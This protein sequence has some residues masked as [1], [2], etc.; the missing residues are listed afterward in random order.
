M[1]GNTVMRRLRKLALAVLAC[2]VFAV[3]APMYFAERARDDT[4]AG[5][6][7]LASPRDLHV[8]TVPVRLSSAPDLMLNRAVIYDY[9]LM[10]P[11]GATSQVLL[12]GPV[13]TLNAAGLRASGATDPDPTAAAEPLPH[14]IQQ[15][16]ALGFDLIAIRRG[17][18]HITMLDG[19]V[20]TLTDIQA[21][22]KKTRRGQIASLGSFTM[23]GQRLA[24]DATFGQPDKKQPQRWPLQVSFRGNL[25]QGTFEGQADLSEDVQLAGKTEL[26]IPS[27]RRIGRWFGL[28]L[29]V[30]E[31]FNAATIKGDL[32]WARRSLAF[33]K[34]HIV[35][36]G[37]EGNGGVVL[38][39]AGER[40]RLEAT[41]D[42]AGLNL[43]PY[44]DAMRT[45]LFG[46]ELPVTWGAAFDASLPMIRYLDADMRISANRVTLKD[47]AFGQGGATIT[48][49]SGKLHADIAELEVPGGGTL[50]AQVTAIMTEAAPRYAVRAKAENLEMGP[51]SASFLGSPALTGRAGLTFD[52][53][54]TGYS[55][56]ELAR[57]LS[58]KA[59][60]SMPEGG[61]VALDLRAVRQAAKAGHRG[62][63]GLAKSHT[64][65]ERLE[66]RSLI[67]DG[68]AFAEDIQARAGTL[69]LA[70]A[71]RFGLV[72]GNMDARLLLKSDAPPDGSQKPADSANVANEAVTLR[73]PWPDPLLRSE[74]PEPVRPMP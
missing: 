71:G 19:S 18:L 39:L 33:E 10:A 54:S 67:I 62:W 70:L 74:E 13:L 34:A 15:I 28:P 30:T 26:A 49:Q 22:V 64:N 23:R 57:R 21:E 24:F 41:L 17:T 61:R 6:A 31:G 47:Y 11:P 8:I 37:N 3:L 29:Y 58:G 46:F 14:I 43:T 5:S 36:D 68:V 16:S 9:D 38:N 52:L 60:L 63:V 51:A 2:L 73:G 59:A 27:L 69:A 20:E 53:T 25:L 48:A 12:D 1:R 4:F 44:L 7:V 72:D 55:L 32:A 45:Q 40:P 65:V 56:T 50:T 42:F 35:V 66:A